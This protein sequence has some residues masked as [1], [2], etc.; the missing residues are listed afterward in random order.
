MHSLQKLCR[1]CLS[2]NWLAR[3][4]VTFRLDGENAERA[5][6]STGTN[7]RPPLGSIETRHATIGKLNCGKEG[8]GSERGG[9]GRGRRMNPFFD[10]LH[11][12]EP[13]LVV[14][15]AAT[16]ADVCPLDGSGE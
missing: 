3:L 11:G 13:G 12:A 9:E 4:S 15:E 1:P 7:V 2:P 5:R 16:F 6:A 10:H 14:V 8:K